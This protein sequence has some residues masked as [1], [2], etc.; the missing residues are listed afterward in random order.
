MKKCFYALLL[1]VVMP[2][3]FPVNIFAGNARIVGISVGDAKQV[4][5]RTEKNGEIKI[6]D[7]INEI[8]GLD[9]LADEHTTVLPPNTVP[10]YLSYPAHDDY[11]F[12]VTGLVLSGGKGPDKKN[13][14]TLGVVKDYK[15]KNPI[16]HGKVTNSKA[17]L[18]GPPLRG[19]CP[20]EDATFDLSYAANGAVIIDPTRPR[21]EGLLMIYEG[22]NK[23]SGANKINKTNDTDKTDG[24]DKKGHYA[25]LGVATSL[26]YG[27]LWPFYRKNYG[28][29]T[30]G[31]H[32]LESGAFG[33][34]VCI[35]NENCLSCKDPKA[36]CKVPPTYGRYPVL[37]P[38]YTIEDAMGDGQSI[39][40]GYQCPSAFLDDV[41]AGGDFI[42]SD[43]YVYSIQNF[44]CP[45]DYRCVRSKQGLSVSRALINGRGE[46]RLAF[47]NWYKA[48]PGRKVL[49]GKRRYPLKLIIPC[50]S[51]LKKDV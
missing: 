30:D 44:G 22:T 42:K 16:T 27:R 19:T 26:D 36:D 23:C 15:I 37:M 50:R 38:T 12:F 18:F 51:P 8:K 2:L 6:W 47:M 49:S 14:W 45:D 7:S 10:E 32:A 41:N 28:S 11:L 43:I 1:F 13:E 40:V 35:S 39:T 24:E 34:D 3:M 31:P 48:S 5:G 17:K 20:P 21:P 25:A 9:T 4:L 46:K 33:P 29:K